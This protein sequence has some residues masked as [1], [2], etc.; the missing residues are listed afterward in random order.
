MTI[1]PSRR[2]RLRQTTAA[3]DSHP[4]DAHVGARVKLR[5]VLVG[6][7]QSQLGEAL[8]LTFQQIQ[9]YERA[10]N[11]ISPSV[12]YHIAQVL[13]VPISFFFDDMGDG[14]TLPVVKPDNPMARPESMELIHHYYGI[15]EAVRGRFFQLVKAMAKN[16]L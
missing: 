1:P 2:L 7:S 13:D 8:G 4:V 11:R 6:L 9:K 15:P 14:Q 16:G 12:L 3:L 5:R 10:G